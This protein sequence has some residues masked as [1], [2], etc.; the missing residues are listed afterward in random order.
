[1]IALIS[2][3]FRPT[4]LSRSKNI[5]RKNI[6]LMSISNALQG[7]SQV[8]QHP[9]WNALQHH[10]EKAASNKTFPKTIDYLNIA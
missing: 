6:Q 7:K 9:W 5:T 3:V 10:S 1:M 8:L 2:L 4:S